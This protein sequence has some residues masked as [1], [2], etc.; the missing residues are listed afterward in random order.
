M[1]DFWQTL[2]HTLSLP[3]SSTIPEPHVS[4]GFP[5][6]PSKVSGAAVQWL[7]KYS[8]EI[9]NPH[10]AYFLLYTILHNMVCKLLVHKSIVE[11]RT[12]VFMSPMYTCNVPCSCE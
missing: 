11:Y 12:L 2:P 4:E 10:E 3:H 6:A 8:L 5:A 9:V 7:A 1:G